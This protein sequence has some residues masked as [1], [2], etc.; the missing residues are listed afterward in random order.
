MSYLELELKEAHVSW[1][2]Q[3]DNSNNLPPSKTMLQTV[4]SQAN[5]LISIL[6]A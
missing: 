6:T 2:S 5:H 3:K 1:S 4:L